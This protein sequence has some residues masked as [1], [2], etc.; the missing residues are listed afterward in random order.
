MNFF[1]KA[2]ALPKAPRYTAI[3][4]VVF[5]MTPF[6]L[7]QT[8]QVG[9][10]VCDTLTTGIT[11]YSYLGGCG[12]YGYLWFR[13]TPSVIPYV[14]G[15]NF[16]IT[17]TAI[18][19]YIWSSLSDTIRIGDAFMIPAPVDSG[20]KIFMSLHS[21][22]SFITRIIG[23]PTVAYENYYCEIKAFLTAAMCYNSLD[24]HGEGPICQVQPAAAVEEGG[25]SH[26]ALFQLF[27]NYPNPFNPQTTI[28]YSVPRASFVKLVIYDMLGQE[29]RSLVDEF[30]H[31]GV[32]SIIWEGKNNNG[33]LVP[34][35]VYT[36][37]I[38]AD[39]FG[40]SSKALM[41]K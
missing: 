28:E 24:Y 16:Q 29:V 2:E 38:A 23:T 9:V 21:S 6:A 13:R 40:Q 32:R 7:A 26:P 41:L 3:L 22:F 15:L 35:G 39:G 14:S 27:Q 19:G 37:R 4:V 31:S 34:S 30:Q 5:C 17:I 1:V 20:V 25:V 36:Y 10:P 33:Q 8:Y 12:P 11:S 18:N